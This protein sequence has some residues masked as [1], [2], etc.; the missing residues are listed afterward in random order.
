MDPLL[1][2]GVGLALAWKAHQLVGADEATRYKSHAHSQ[3]L[4]A[5]EVFP[6]RL[7]DVRGLHWL[8]LRLRFGHSAGLS[9]QT[10][11]P[12]DA[13]QRRE[14]GTSIS[15]YW[16]GLVARLPRWGGSYAPLFSLYLGLALNDF[17]L[18]EQADIKDFMV[19][20]LAV[21]GSVLIPF[22]RFVRVRLGGGLRALVGASSE[23][24]DAHR[25]SVGAAIGFRVEVSLRGRIL[26]GLG[27]LARF[28]Y[29]RVRGT[30]EPLGANASELELQDTL[31]TAGLM[32]T[33]EV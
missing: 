21:G 29:E 6:F 27:Y 15:C 13:N 20:E 12:A 11:D 22:H 33:Y 31:L 25:V 18:L 26:D 2:V 14:I 32:L 30:L 1:D 4:M 24:L 16:A 10:A 9:T 5:A 3:F 28:G 19:N 8:G 7:T 17:S 23:Q